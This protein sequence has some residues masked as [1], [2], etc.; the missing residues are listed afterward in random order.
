MGSCPPED[1]GNKHKV[2]VAMVGDKMGINL[3]VNFDRIKEGIDSYCVKLKTRAE[4]AVVMSPLL[5]TEG[6]GKIKVGGERYNRVRD[7]AA[8][9]KE[10]A[11]KHGLGFIDT[12]EICCQKH[13]E[14]NTL[15]FFQCFEGSHKYN[16]PKISHDIVRDAICAYLGF[17]DAA[18]MVRN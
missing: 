11:E 12:F 17:I 10:S 8:V 6:D 5:Q 7:I 15:M 4:H 1:E 9:L 18:D 3:A 2:I 13:K 14:D 16:V